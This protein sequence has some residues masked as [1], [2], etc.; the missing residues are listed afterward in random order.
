MAGPARS[1]GGGAGRP[2]GVRRG[3]PGGHRC[4]GDTAPGGRRRE[5]VFLRYRRCV[6]NFPFGVKWPGN[7]DRSPTRRT[8][9]TGPK[10]VPSG[11]PTP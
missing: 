4:A 1:G 11:G 7:A 8:R 3:P 10:L 2:R 5:R 9:L 6:R